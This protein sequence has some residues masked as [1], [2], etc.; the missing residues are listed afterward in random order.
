MVVRLRNILKSSLMGNKVL[1]IIG[2]NLVREEELDA[3]QL[4]GVT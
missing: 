3:Y 4:K 2:V 1:V